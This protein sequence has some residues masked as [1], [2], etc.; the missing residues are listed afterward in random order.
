M[1][2][3][4]LIRCSVNNKSPRGSISGCA[5]DFFKKE[6]MKQYPEDQIIEKDL[7][8]V[9]FLHQSMTDKTLDGWFDENAKALIAELKNIDKLVIATSTMNYSYPALLKNYVDKICLAG[10]TFKYKYDKGKSGSV[11][12]LTNIKSAI[13]FAQG[14]PLDWYQFSS[15]PTNLEGLLHF[16]GT[17]YAGCVMM[18]GTK[19]P[20]NANKTKEEIVHQFEDQLIDLVKKMD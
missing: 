3:I 17:K 4:L 20:E 16:L 8:E 11:G 15:L 18:Q 1:K 2:K 5:L 14:S 7:N 9:E 10:E 6:Y 12:L 13:I 19:I